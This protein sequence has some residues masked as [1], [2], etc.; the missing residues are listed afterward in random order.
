M[1]SRQNPLWLLAIGGALILRALTT[2]K[3]QDL[4]ATPKPENSPPPR[5][6]RTQIIP[7]QTPFSTMDIEA[8]ARMLASENPRQSERL[9]VEQIWTQLRSKTKDQSL[10]DRI[11]HGSGWGKQGSRVR[12]GGLRPVSTD[13][14][15][16][17]TYRRLAHRVL[18]G[19]IP[20]TLPGAKRFFEPAVSDRALKIGKEARR[21]LAAGEPLTKQELRLRY[22]KKSAAEVRKD[23]LRTSKFL[24][25]IDGIEFY[26]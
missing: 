15:T 1:E 21:K 18:R 8:A 2:T 23:W 13:E 3:G 14:P 6:P 22:Y 10:Y 4:P 24:G 16:N 19:E 25:T 5:K 12:P 7:A 11:T 26:T 9:H 17:D 20:S